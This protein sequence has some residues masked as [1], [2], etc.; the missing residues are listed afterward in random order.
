MQFHIGL[1]LPTDSGT[2]KSDLQTGPKALI[3]PC[4]LDE[5]DT[6]ILDGGCCEFFV[7]VWFQFSF[8]KKS[9]M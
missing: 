7:Y 6:P 1:A 4:Q 8:Y 2:T 9:N 3:W 5:F